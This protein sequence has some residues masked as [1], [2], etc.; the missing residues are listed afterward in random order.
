[1]RTSC[2][3]LDDDLWHSSKL[4]LQVG[5]LR[6][7]KETVAVGTKAGLLTTSPSMGADR[8]APTVADPHVRTLSRYAILRTNAIATSSLFANGSV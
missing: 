4:G 6:S 7:H 3:S 2:R 1:M 5:A 8:W